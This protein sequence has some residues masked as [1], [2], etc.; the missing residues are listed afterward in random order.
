MSINFP[1]K[2]LEETLKILY[3]DYLN[4]QEWQ[5]MIS[6]NEPFHHVKQR[7][8]IYINSKNPP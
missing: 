4:T 7:E 3:S 2:N 5:M 8:E 1:F 6:E